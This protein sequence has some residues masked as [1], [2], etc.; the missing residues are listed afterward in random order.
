M[1]FITSLFLDFIC[2]L[3]TVDED[4]ARLFY[5]AVVINGIPVISYGLMASSLSPIFVDVNGRR[6]IIIR[7][8][9]WLFTT[10]AMLYLYSI[11]T[12]LAPSDILVA[13]ANGVAMIITGFLANILP[14]PFDLISL[15]LSL[16]T[17]CYVMRALNTS[18]ELAI[19]EC[20]S[21]ED[22]SYR[23]ALMGA[24]ALTTF[25]WVGVPAIWMLAYFG[26]LSHSAEELLYEL[27]DF[28]IKAGISCMILH[29]SLKTRAEKQQERMR[30]EL[31]EERGRTIKALHESALMKVSLRIACCRGR[32]CVRLFS[33]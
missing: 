2:W 11:L 18:I 25:S 29:S 4:K 9:Q 16:S 22:A 23:R 24:H 19:S 8:M 3:W 7:Y 26:L 6:L 17:F 27:F 1:A 13:M 15:A 30:A 33:F 20:C 31:V 10:P 14:S 28:V 21:S 12:S 5:I 32:A